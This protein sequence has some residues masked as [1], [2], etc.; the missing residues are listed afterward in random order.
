MQTRIDLILSEI[1]KH[2]GGARYTLVASIVNVGVALLVFARKDGPLSGNGEDDGGIADRI[3]EV[4]T[5]WTGCGPCFL[6]NKGAVGV[7]LAV[8][9]RSSS[10]SSEEEVFTFVNAHLTAH[11]PDRYL[12]KRL[13]NYDYIVSTLLFPPLPSHQD[14]DQKS[15]RTIY[16]T[17]HLFFFGDLNFRVITAKSIKSPSHTSLTSSSSSDANGTTE[18]VTPAQRDLDQLTIERLKPTSQ[19]RALT[20]LR[21]GPFW[22]F[23]ATYKFELG[24]V[25][26]Y[27]GKRTPSWTDRILYASRF[28]PVGLEQ[29][30]EICG[31][32]SQTQ[33]YTSPIENLVYTSVPSYTTSDHKPIVSLLRIRSSH[34]S[35]SHPQTTTL[36]SHPTYAPTLPTP[37]QFYILKRHLGRVLGWILG[38][39]A[40]VIVKLGGGMGAKVGVVNF[41]VGILVW[42]W[43]GSGARGR[44]EGDGNV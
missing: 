32:S 35:S 7:R 25:G 3:T 43:W 13:D 30:D 12:Q 40:W 34:A 2:N 33:P 20:Y 10:S 6:G 37:D 31:T 18:T 38:W 17:T 42:R 44:V 4:Q 36:S 15:L 19:R 16:D 26:K 8:K 14:Q 9:P 41:F 28:D 29:I 5:Q 11:A 23:D 39:S 24:S 22:E 1:E 21:E 27:S